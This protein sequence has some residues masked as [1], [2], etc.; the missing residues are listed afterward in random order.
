MYHVNSKSSHCNSPSE[1]LHVRASS[2][3]L[4]LP[5]PDISE[6]TDTHTQN[7]PINITDSSVGCRVLA[8]LLPGGA[9][10]LGMSGAPLG[11]QWNA[12]MNHL[13][14]K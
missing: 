9:A 5:V 10:P 3:A 2:V 14:S 8:R 6:I 7:T 1:A 12:I 13:D 11:S 4:L